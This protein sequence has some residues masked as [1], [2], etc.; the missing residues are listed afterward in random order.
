MLLHSQRCNRS[1]EPDVRGG[2]SF[3]PQSHGG[4]S[5]LVRLCPSLAHISS[6]RHRRAAE[7]APCKPILTQ[8]DVRSYGILTVRRQHSATLNVIFSCTSLPL[9]YAKG[10]VPDSARG[11]IP[12]EEWVRQHTGARANV[13]RALCLGPQVTVGRLARDAGGVLF[14]SMEIRAP[15]ELTQS[16][17]GKNGLHSG[18]R[19]KHEAESIQIKRRK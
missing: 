5:E 13:P 3:A 14:M 2:H 18:D 7:S 9:K 11:F 10:R 6:V 16:V 12:W 15:E 4:S 19:A 17:R 1:H 8:I